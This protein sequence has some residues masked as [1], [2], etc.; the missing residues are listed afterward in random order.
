MHTKGTS[1]GSSYVHLLHTVE[2]VVGVVAEQA[3]REAFFTEVAAIYPIP[4][5]TSTTVGG[6]L[7]D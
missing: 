7:A 1:K 4:T 3:L 2:A 5:H 6:S